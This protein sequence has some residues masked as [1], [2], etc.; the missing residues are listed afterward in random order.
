[1]TTNKTDAILETSRLRLEPITRAHAPLL[2]E[3]LSDATMYTFIPTELPTSVDE[4]AARFSRLE[5]R[6]SPDGQEQWL[7]W[8][9]CLRNNRQYV[10][11]V[12][13]TVQADGTAFLAYQFNVHY[14]QQGYATE[15][16][17]KII[18]EMAAHYGVTTLMAQVDT[19]NL[20]SNRLLERLGF[21]QIETIPQA[22]Y[23][24]GRWSDEYVWSLVISS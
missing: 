4:L 20:P 23:F 19:R 18:T 7:N 16:C 8:A 17:Q 9:V 24:K 22:D 10:G 13:T 1:M 12:Q 6:Q 14:R 2:F 11:L 15:A 21:K 3:T 5:T